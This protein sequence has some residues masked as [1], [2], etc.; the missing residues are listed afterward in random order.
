LEKAA[1]ACHIECAAQKARKMAKAKVK[2]KA[3][4]KRLVEKK[5]KKKK[6]LEY[7]Q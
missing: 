4:K 7:L 5:K 3:K 6:R 2:E 1:E